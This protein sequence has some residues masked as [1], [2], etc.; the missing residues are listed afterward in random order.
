MQK[1]RTRVANN[2]AQII[3]R[4]MEVLLAFLHPV[5]AKRCGMIFEAVQTVHPSGLMRKWNFSTSAKRDLRA[6][7]HHSGTQFARVSTVSANGVCRL[8]HAHRSPEL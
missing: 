1:I 8:E 7:S 6:V 3:L 5:E 2:R 4:R